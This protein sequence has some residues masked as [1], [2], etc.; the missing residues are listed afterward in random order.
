MS[1]LEQGYVLRERLMPLIIRQ[2]S[3]NPSFPVTLRVIRILILVV[4]QHLSITQSECGIA[5]GFVNHMLDPDAATTWRRALSM[6]MFQAIY[7][8]PALV[9]EIYARFDEEQS[10]MSIVRDNL[11]AFVRLASEKPALIGVG[12]QSTA[13]AG[14]PIARDG[15]T[16]QVA[17]EA[18]GAAGVI[19]IVD[20]S[21]SNVPG[22]SS[23]WSSL[24]TPCLDQFDKSEAPA[25]PE[26]YI[27]SL[28]LTSVNSLTESLAKFVLPLT[29]YHESR[30]KRK[31]RV[32]E[33]ARQESMDPS[34]LETPTQ[35][36]PKGRLTRSQ[37]YKKRTVPINPLALDSHTSYPRIRTSAAMVSEC[38]PAVLATC[39]TFLN[40]ALDADYYRA[41]VRSIQKFTQVAGLL[42]LSTPR[43]AFL[44]LLKKAAV[45]AHIFNAHAMPPSTVA[46][47]SSG[48]FGNARG[49]LS[50]DSLVSQASTL[51]SD[52]TH[53]SSSD[54]GPPSLNT[55]NLL[56]LR[57]LLNLAIALGP[58]LD[59]SW[60]IVFE[61]LQQ[62]DIIM[63]TSTARGALSVNRPSLQVDGKNGN[64]PAPEQNL[65]SEVAA[66]HAAVS[67]LFES[68]I[69]FPNDSFVEVLVALS[70]LLHDRPISQGGLKVTASSQT[71]TLERRFSNFSG[72]P[73]TAGAQARDYRSALA[74]LGD[75]VT[76]NVERFASFD[77]TESGWAYL[78]QEL[79][80]TSTN[81]SIASPIR[82]M[83]ANI[84]TRVAQDVLKT[85]AIEVLE[86]RQEVERRVLAALRSEIDSLYVEH[87]NTDPELGE[88][89]AD[90][91]ATALDALKSILEHCGDTLTAGWD[92]ALAIILSVFEDDEEPDE[93][94]EGTAESTA[95]PGSSKNR[96]PEFISLELGRSA[97][98]A[99]QLI[100]TDFLNLV[101][102]RCLVTLIDTLSRFCS[103]SEDLNIS[104]TVSGICYRV[105][106][107]LIGADRYVLLEYIRLPP[108][109]YRRYIAGS[110]CSRSSGLGGC[111]RSDSGQSQPW[112]NDCIMALSS[113]A[114]DDHCY[115]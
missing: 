65:H 52:K 39:S 115:R 107:I 68:T 83:A 80:T 31:A 50:V 63:A 40:A 61:A 59:T 102:D 25:I 66:V 73:I 64:E 45:P 46:P 35:E 6:E 1:H 74:R 17:V 67:R 98:G 19:G 14:K 53:K 95:G 42:R 92:S 69:D 5:L 20:I 58:T 47:E 48:V 90:V 87:D 71:P 101:P 21:E 93:T 23:Q 27:H 7:S 55:R 105:H 38:W 26:T 103:Q 43:D 97:F 51:S 82:V 54:T 60:T 10:E 28:V 70:S 22:I 96:V 34:G 94:T 29:V 32:Q 57:A 16:E 37:S 111:R 49:L 33:S 24:R 110:H 36:Q 91:H 88:T 30:S 77:V 84:L 2:L 112:F 41:L 113:G 8:D 12:N 104:L 81:R 13:P 75:L 114:I 108:W 76:L 85:A 86:V 79:I 15:P 99:L 89:D 3:E 18:G 56:C 4:R 62:A 109:T 78:T 106:K 44:T 9:L 72:V 11:S 100:C